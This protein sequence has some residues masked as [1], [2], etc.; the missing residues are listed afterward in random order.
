MH[1]KMGIPQNPLA[2]RP[3]MRHPTYFSTSY[4]LKLPPMHEHGLRRLTFEY[5]KNSPMLIN[6]YKR[7]RRLLN[8][9]HV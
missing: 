7:I 9:F 6:L 3:A 5:G 2:V 4:S 8:I 1:E